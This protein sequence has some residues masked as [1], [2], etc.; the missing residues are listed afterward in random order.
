MHETA[1]S[2]QPS[3]NCCM[4]QL[5]PFHTWDIASPSPNTP[6]ARQAD[7]DGHDT[8][9]SPPVVPAADRFVQRAPFH[10]SASGTDSNVLPTA[11]Q[12][13]CEGHDTALRKAPPEAEGM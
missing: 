4:V 5:E 9:L 3:G 2:C 7:E 11:M 12:I 1:V 6:T 13:W 10:D 8:P